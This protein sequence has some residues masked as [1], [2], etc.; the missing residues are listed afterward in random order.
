M[1]KFLSSLFIL[2]LLCFSC[3]P[4]WAFVA[5]TALYGS[6]EGRVNRIRIPLTATATGGTPNFTSYA[7][8]P[9]AYTNIQLK[10]GITGWYLYEVEIDPGTTGPTNGAWDLDITDANGYVISTTSLDNLS[11]TATD[12][13]RWAESSTGY[14]QIWG[15]WTISIG[16]NAVNDASVTVY[17][18]FVSN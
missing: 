11:S 8:S 12:I 5:G 18:T 1:K 10:Y 13:Y 3:L 14:P 9:T 15:T 4:C 16:D 17:L 6:T 2:T 7:L